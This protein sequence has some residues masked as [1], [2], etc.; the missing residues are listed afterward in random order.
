[1]ILLILARNIITHSLPYK[2]EILWSNF[3]YLLDSN[4]IKR[5]ICISRARPPK[6]KAAGKLRDLNLRPQLNIFNDLNKMR[7]IHRLAARPEK[8]RQILKPRLRNSAAQD[9]KPYL[10]EPGK[11]ILTATRE[12]TPGV[13][14]AF[15][16]QLLSRQNSGYC[17]DP[18]SIASRWGDRGT[19]DSVQMP[20]KCVGIRCLSTLRGFRPGDLGRCLRL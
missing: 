3:S 12:L 16:R 20:R 15:G 2:T 19:R 10:I 4:R 8:L 11:N 18:G 1:M 7:I 13:R 14:I 6:L 5:E 9:I 17:A